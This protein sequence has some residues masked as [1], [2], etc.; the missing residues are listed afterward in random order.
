[1]D[2]FS[3]VWVTRE[4]EWKKRTSASATGWCESVGVCRPDSCWMAV[5]AYPARRAGQ[6]IR[7]TQ[8]EAGW[9]GRHFP[10]PLSCSRET[11]GR[12]VEGRTAIA[13]RSDHA[14]LPEY[15]HAPIRLKVDDWRRAGFPVLDTVVPA[16]PHARLFAD[17]EAHW[18]A[19]QRKFPG[20]VA[21]MASPNPPIGIYRL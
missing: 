11:G 13:L 9:F 17:R 2:T 19:L 16:G 5:I 1:M 10:T 21:W 6:L 4:A 20:L 3:P 14:S 12:I 8:L 7:P 15:I 18:M